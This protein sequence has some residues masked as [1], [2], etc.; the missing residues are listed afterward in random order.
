ML[1]LLSASPVRPGL[2]RRDDIITAWPAQSVSYNNTDNMGDSDMSPKA[3]VTYD[4]NKFQVEFNV[5][6]YLPEVR[7]FQLLSLRK[8][9]NGLRVDFGKTANSTLTVEPPPQYIVL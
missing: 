1:C 6:E 9:S 5:S 4:Q 3:R 8:K 2:A 7:W